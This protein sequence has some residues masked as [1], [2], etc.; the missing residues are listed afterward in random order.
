[1]GWFRARNRRQEV[2][3]I[4]VERALRARSDFIK[5]AL[6]H[7]LTSARRSAPAL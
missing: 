7:T 2:E 6:V 4:R 1:M 3:P 5:H